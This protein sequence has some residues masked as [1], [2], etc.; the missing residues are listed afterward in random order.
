MVQIRHAE[1]F[2]EIAQ[3]LSS[4]TSMVTYAGQGRSAVAVDCQGGYASPHVLP[5]GRET[6]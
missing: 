6:P 2:P 3:A 1:Y 4:S 5:I